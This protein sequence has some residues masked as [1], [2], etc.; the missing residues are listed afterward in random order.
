MCAYCCQKF[1]R[2]F[3]L[4]AMVCAVI[5]GASEARGS[6]KLR[7][8]YRRAYGEASLKGVMPGDAVIVEGNEGEEVK[9]YKT[10]HYM[11]HTKMDRTA[12]L[13]IGQHIDLMFELYQERFSGFTPIEQGLMKLYLFEEEDE[14]VEFMHTHNVRGSNS[15]G[16][17]VYKENLHCLAIWIG[18]KLKR[19]VR[20]V[21]QHEGFHQFAWHYIG[22]ELPVWMNEGLAQYFEDAVIASGELETGIGDVHRINTVK[23]MIEDRQV[24]RFERLMAMDH[25][26][27]GLVLGASPKRAGMLYAQAWSIVD[28]L[29]H[30]REG[31]YA[32]GVNRYLKKLSEGEE[33]EEA[34]QSIFGDD[35]E[36]LRKNWEVYIRKL[37]PSDVNCAVE[38]MKF[39]AIALKHFHNEKIRIPREMRLMRKLLRQYQIEVSWTINGETETM[40]A[41]D[42][43]LYS[44][45]KYGYAKEFDILEPTKRNLPP[46]IVASGLSPEPMLVW[47][48]NEDGELV[49]DITYR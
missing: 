42:E 36:E 47:E 5:G 22:K 12:V 11:I 49:S 8:A 27:W 26:Q 28:F 17:F 44:F 18:D 37:E 13:P 39:L 21:L 38:R 48:Y 46:R 33:A 9:R 16:M 7:Q 30:G 1:I 29:I 35:Y 2:T 14:Y 10:K 23:K 34:F 15:G 3:M 6:E 45:E 24:V 25:E 19:E 43:R 4:V 40:L 32:P 31:K 20:S 41:N